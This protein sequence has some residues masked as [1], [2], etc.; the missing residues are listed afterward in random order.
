MSKFQKS[1]RIARLSNTETEEYA[2]SKLHPELQPVS[3]K[4]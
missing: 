2:K 1:S 4:F 3:E